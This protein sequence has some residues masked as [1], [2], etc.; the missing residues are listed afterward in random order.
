MTSGS[1]SSSCCCRPAD[2][3][4]KSMDKKMDFALLT[5]KLP[6]RVGV[7]PRGASFTST[8]RPLCGVRVRASVVD[9]NE[10]SSNFVKRMEQAWLIS[11]VLFMD[12]HS[13]FETI[14][15][16]CYS[17]CKFIISLEKSIQGEKIIL[18][19]QVY[20]LLNHCVKLGMKF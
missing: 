20:N 3:V 16:F 17:L 6:L 2:A 1:S 10:S 14:S 11:Q 13:I 9:S 19:A 8:R 18:V 12:F 4:T 7:V 5:I 15:C